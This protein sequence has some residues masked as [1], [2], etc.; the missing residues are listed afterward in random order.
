MSISL[1]TSGV[2]YPDTTIQTTAAVGGGLGT[3]QAWKVYTSPDR[4]LNVT[5]TNSTGRPIYVSIAVN[6]QTTGATLG[7]YQLYVD[8]I[9]IDEL[10]MAANSGAF[11]IQRVSFFQAIVPNGSS[12]K[13]MNSGST[14]PNNPVWA[15]LTSE[16]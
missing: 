11:Y 7:G 14:S 15:E 12:Y 9:L 16:T 2:Q 3:T 5:Y 4:E 13:T 6:C 1:I 8:G 10:L